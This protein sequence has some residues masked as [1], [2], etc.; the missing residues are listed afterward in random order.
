MKCTSNSPNISFLIPGVILEGDVG[1]VINQNC[2]TSPFFKLREKW[3]YTE[4]TGRVFQKTIKYSK[5]LSL[6]LQKT[7]KTSPC[8][9]FV[10]LPLNPRKFHVLRGGKCVIICL[11]KFPFRLKHFPQ[12][13]H[14]YGFCPV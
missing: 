4:Y 2:P 6:L 5:R 8:F 7:V 3:F 13:L 11:V 1:E 14:S 12:V 10:G 9:K